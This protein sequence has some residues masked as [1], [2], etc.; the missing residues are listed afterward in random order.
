MRLPSTLL[1]GVVAVAALGPLEH[2][3]TTLGHGAPLTPHAG[4]LAAEREGGRGEAARGGTD[5]AGVGAG[6]GPGGERAGEGGGGRG[7]SDGEAAGGASRAARTRAAAED[8]TGKAPGESRDG[9][10]EGGREDDRGGG[11]DHGSQGDP[12]G[13][14]PPARAFA[15]PTDGREREPDELLALDLD[16]SDL[17]RARALGFTVRE[18]RV[19]PF[20]GL[21]VTRLGLP[22]GLP[23]AA[24]Q[25]RLRSATP[26]RT[27]APEDSYAPQGDPPGPAGGCD[28]ERCWGQRAIGWRPAASCGAGGV[29]GLIDT[30]VDPSAAALDGRLLAARSF[31]PAGSGPAGRDH[32]TALASLLAGGAEGLLPAAG[33]L[34]AEVFADAGGGRARAGALEVAEALDWLAGHRPAVV[35]ASF[36][37]PDNPVLAAAVARVLAR[38]VPVVAAAG[39]DGP[40]APP[41]YPAAY[42]GVL[43]ATAVDRGLRPYRKANH[44]GYVAFAAPGVDVPAG[45]SGRTGTSYAAAFVTAAAAETVLRGLA[46]DPPSLERRLAATALDLGP[47][48]RDPVFGWGLVR[49]PDGCATPS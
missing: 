28:A 10:G 39:N 1:L 35:N 34:V 8:P 48:G 19:L 47:P 49:F 7:G 29:V 25:V 20:L 15:Q 23:L 38:G 37:G 42:P 43:A 26:G 46:R 11:S 21:V 6:R 27:V 41:A 4:A 3:L 24:A 18:R 12:G 32:G 45:A 30:G 2:A 31:V 9:A 13:T 17:E 14:T 33:L 16:A 44:G 5:H 36:A 40:E 22:P